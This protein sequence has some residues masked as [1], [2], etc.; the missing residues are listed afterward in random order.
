MSLPRGAV[1]LRDVKKSFRAYHAE[2]LKHAAISLLSG[3][4]LTERREVLKGIDLRVEPGERLGII[5]RN[6]AGKST[7]F[8]V[9][10]GI[11]SPDAGQIQMGGRVSPLI[12]I[13]AGLVPDLTGAENIRLNAAVLGLTRKQVEQKFST[14]V[15]FA[16]LADFLDTPAR[17]Y[18]NG[19]Q[20]RLGFSVAINVDAD[21]LLIDEVLAVGDAQFQQ[22]CLD[23]LR[24]LSERGATIIV[25]S[26]DLSA[27]RG[28]CHRVAWLEKGRIESVGETDAVLEE[29]RVQQERTREG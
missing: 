13:T 11:L 15:E 28:F 3:A 23:R 12:E 26:H 16:E 10:S 8:R 7:L 1:V 29:F 18:S 19:M 2:T 9:I 6:G 4:R 20:A 24:E 22:R 25:V 21:I 17:Y 14:I 27:L 5:G